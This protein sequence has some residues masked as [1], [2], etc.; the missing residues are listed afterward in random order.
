[1]IG[2]KEKDAGVAIIRGTDVDAGLADAGPGIV[3]SGAVTYERFGS[4]HLWAGKAVIAPGAATGAHH[5]GALDSFIYVVSGRA[6]M[7]WGDHLEHSAEAGPGDFIYVPP[8]VPH[9]E[10][11]A[12]DTEPLVSILVRS[13]KDPVMVPL[14]KN[15]RAGERAA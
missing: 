14:G 7:R 2:R 5:H 3:R 15:A 11:N 9:Q 6:R 1:M 8:F 12:S 4:E 10:M 13:D